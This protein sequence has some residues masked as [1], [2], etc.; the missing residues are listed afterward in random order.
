[1]EA[2]FML[3]AV[4]FAFMLFHDDE[5]REIR[6][7]AARKQKKEAAEQEQQDPSTGKQKGMQR[8]VDKHYVLPQNGVF[9]WV[10]FPHYL[11]EWVEWT[12]FAI[13]GGWRF[14]P[15]RTFVFNEVATM[16]PRALQ[17]MRWYVEKFGREKV[18]GRWAVL[19]G[20]A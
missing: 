7:A 2:G 15:G 8:G 5:L 16:L 13:M 20:I 12:G 1:M 19:P 11:F 3:W 6:R 14:T 10:L 4:G 17:G 18:G 9:K